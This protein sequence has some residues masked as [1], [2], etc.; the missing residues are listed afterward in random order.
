MPS[1]RQR[2]VWTARRRPH[3]RRMHQE[4]TTQTA[5]VLAWD[6]ST[7][8]VGVVSYGIYDQRSAY[9]F[10]DDAERDAQRSRVWHDVPIRYR[11]G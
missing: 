8:N 10:R 3:R 9:R 11:R 5:V 4:A 6:A 7:D 1:C 2:H